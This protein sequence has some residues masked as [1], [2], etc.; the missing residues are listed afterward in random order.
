MTSKHRSYGFYLNR[1]AG[2]ER[3]GCWDS[4]KQYPR[5]TLPCWT[6]LSELKGS[7]RTKASLTLVCLCI[8]VCLS[9]HLWSVQSLSPHPHPQC[10]YLSKGQILYEINEQEESIELKPHVTVRDL[11]NSGPS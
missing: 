5:E 9:L 6:L 11:V 4:E 8:S 10:P 2:D 3:N 7:L 1:I